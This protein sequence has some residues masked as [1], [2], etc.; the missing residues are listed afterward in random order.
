MEHWYGPAMKFSIFPSYERPWDELLELA[1]FAEQ[2]GLHGLWYA[3]HLMQQTDDDTVA[4][5]PAAECWTMLAA[6]AATVPRLQL[7]SMV[8]PVTIHHPVVL[9]K[10]AA[11]VDHIS[12]GRAVLGLGAGWQV[13]EHTAYGF[14]LFDPGERV[15]H[16]EEAIEVIHRLLHDDRA[17]FHG[18]W[19][20]LDGAP[21]AP[22]PERLPL[23]V[24][25]GS[26]RMMRITARWADS[27]NTWGNPV[28]LRERTELFARACATVQRDMS[29]VARSAQAMIFLTD[30]DAARDRLRASAPEGRSLVGGPAELVDLLGAYVE[31]G[32]DEFAIPDFTLGRTPEKRIATLGRLRDEVLTHL[33]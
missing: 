15:T 9:A 22:K 32:V 19:Y 27:W 29:T 4:D 17:T 8:S 10:R 7:T 5:G 33:G 20:H 13:N 21:F 3:D 6:I 16:F 24:G 30:D 14:E 31:A 28:Q 23:L 2:S 1:R 25:T 11:T 26:P 18:R 12:G